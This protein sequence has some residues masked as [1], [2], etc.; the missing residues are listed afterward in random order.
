MVVAI[1]HV[2]YSPSEPPGDLDIVRNSSDIDIVIGGHTHTLVNPEATDGRTP[3]LVKNAEGRD[4]L[5]TQ[6]GGKGRY[7]GEI[8]INLDSLTFDYK[9]IPVDSRLDKYP[10]PEMTEVI[11]RYRLG[12]DSLMNLKVGE[13][14]I[15][16]EQRGMPLL[17]FISDF[18]LHRGN[19]ISENVDLGIINKYG[20]R[21]PLPKGAITEG[22]IISLM[23]FNNY[24]VVLDIKGSDLLDAFDVMAVIDGN[25][26]SKGVEAT[27]DPETD[28]CL[29]VKINGKPLDPE[30]TYRVCTID[31]LANGGDY[32]EP[33]RK[34]TIVAR[35]EDVLY[36]DIISYFRNDLKGKKIKPSGEVR[37]KPVK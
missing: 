6:V 13:S 2:G 24:T 8:D 7:L 36:K 34:G 19:Q 27:F 22:M 31:Y 5:V 18:M 35:S 4:V 33:L 15:E 17:N 25:G 23:P 21:I 14:A 12:I 3:W 28:K 1:T 30:K 11:E 29:E 32:M 9:V 37:M 20:L 16:L 26:V 10:S